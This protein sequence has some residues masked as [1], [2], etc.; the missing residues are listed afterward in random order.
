MKK[1][2]VCTLVSVAA[3][4]IMI[5]A[6]RAQASVKG[7]TI[8]INFGADQPLPGGSALDPT[9]VAGV[10]GVESANWNNA[11]LEVGEVDNLVRDIQG[12]ATPTDASV[13]W[14]ATNTWCNV[15]A[16][17]CGGEFNNNFSGDDLTLMSGYL[18]Q[19][20]FDV[21]IRVRISNLPDDMA[22]SYDVYVYF[23][24][25]VSGRGG[26]YTVNG[27]TKSGTVGGVPFIGPDYVEDPG[28]DHSTRGN[29]LV[30]RGLSGST[31]DISALNTFGET[32]RAP[33]NAIEIVNTSQ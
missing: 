24:G 30:F 29:Y 33:I 1:Q 32:P 8:S 9:A 17:S 15:G 27:M 2:L 21:T 6:S 26:E 19:N 31:V 7:D 10:P 16:D 13:T 23:L 25:G 12:T 11:F 28:Q 22:A 3:L 5:V 20:A 14:F 18:D 4:V